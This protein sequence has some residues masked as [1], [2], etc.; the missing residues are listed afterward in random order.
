MLSKLINAE[1]RTQKAT[2]LGLTVIA[3]AVAA[4]VLWS[5]AA[6]IGEA[7]ASLVEARERAGI[8]LELA[9]TDLSALPDDGADSAGNALFIEAPSLVLARAALQGRINAIAKA[10]NVLVASA[11]NLPDLD[12]G[13]S[14]MIGLR[15]DFSGTYL[16]VNKTVHAI[17]TSMPPL[18]VKEMDVRAAGVAKAGTPPELAAQLRIFGAV[19]FAEAGD[20]A[21]QKP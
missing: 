3:V 18:L 20:Q 4:F 15:I 6:S 8:L 9:R 5:F 17:E 21:V 12:E 11:G 7:R 19:R 10:N 14:M 1:M 13:G 2:A 16:D